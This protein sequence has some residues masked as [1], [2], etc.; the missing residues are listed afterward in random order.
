[1]ADKPKQRRKAVRRA[2][3]DTPTPGGAAISPLERAT[4]GIRRATKKRKKS[5]KR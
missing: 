4:K 2:L 1:M 5:G 3:R